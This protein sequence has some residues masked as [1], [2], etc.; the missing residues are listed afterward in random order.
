MINP[1]KENTI[2]KRRFTNKLIV[3]GITSLEERPPFN[4]FEYFGLDN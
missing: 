2:S 1:R 4:D 3:K